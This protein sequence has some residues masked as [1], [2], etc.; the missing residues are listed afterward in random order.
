MPTGT[1]AHF[2]TNHSIVIDPKTWVKSLDQQYHRNAKKY[3]SVRLSPWKRIKSKASPSSL[4]SCRPTT[5]G[6]RKQSICQRKTNP[7]ANP[8]P[9]DWKKSWRRWQQRDLPWF[10]EGDYLGERDSCATGSYGASNLATSH[11]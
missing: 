1:K 6:H 2:N 7:G 9:M 3:Q 11:G 5:S 10:G 4:Q 8:L